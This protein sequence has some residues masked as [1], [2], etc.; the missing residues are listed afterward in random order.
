MNNS[1]P[2]ILCIH[3]KQRDENTFLLARNALEISPGAK[4]NFK[5]V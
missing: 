1:I 5:L 2:W 3:E 4:K